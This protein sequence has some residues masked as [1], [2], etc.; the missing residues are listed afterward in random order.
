[1]FVS[2]EKVVEYFRD[3]ALAKVEGENYLP[4]WWWGNPWSN[5][6]QI[7]QIYIDGAPVNIVKNYHVHRDGLLIIEAR[8]SG[9]VLLYELDCFVHNDGYTSS[10]RKKDLLFGDDENLDDVYFTYNF[11]RMMRNLER[12]KFLHKPD[13]LGSFLIDDLLG[14]I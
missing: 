9:R 2:V 12:R 14:L 6:F 11:Y 4:F 5:R 13:G 8:L 3:D 1:M 7:V 10:Y